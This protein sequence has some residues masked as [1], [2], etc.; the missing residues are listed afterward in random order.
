MK[1]IY[2]AKD[3]QLDRLTM[4]TIMLDKNF[5]VECPSVNS[6]LEKNI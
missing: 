1:G 3:L 5:S 6:C 2:A 4:P